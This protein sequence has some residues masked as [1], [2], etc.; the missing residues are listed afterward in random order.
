MLDVVISQKNIEAQGIYSFELRCPE[1]KYLPEFSAG[2]HIDVQLGSNLVR[3][4]SLCN[5]PDERDRY[6]IAVLKEPN[7]RGGSV[8][9]HNG[10]KAGDTL[11]ISAPRNLFSLTTQADRY[12]LMAGGIGITPILCM[13]EELQQK[14]ADFELHYCSR[15]PAL[16]A[17]TDRIKASEFASR[18]Q[19]HFDDGP[20]TQK[21]NATELLQ[22]PQAGTHLYICGPGG[23]IEHVLGTAR[24]NGWPEDQ[25]HREYFAAPATRSEQDRPFQVE[26]ASNGR[27]YEIPADKTVFEVLDSAGIDIP[28]SCEQ[29]ICGSCITRI[30]HGEPEHRDEF[31]TQSEHEKNDQFTPCCSRAKSPRLV[32]DL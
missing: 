6:L 20:A 23:F 29:G 32:L 25:L 11:K 1:G 24:L 15:S 27:I 10:L 7:S 17:F 14:G 30:L 13:A 22:S 4:Y 21:L 26:L 9:M 31:M 12:I 8:A 19:L 16:A 5:H 2:A 18:V 3:Q 28:V